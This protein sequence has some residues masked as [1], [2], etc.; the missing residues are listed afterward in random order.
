MKEEH[1]FHNP[2]LCK[3]PQ[4]AYQLLS[5]LCWL[6]NVAVKTS[7]LNM[8]NTVFL[9][10]RSNF[11]DDWAP[12][13][14]WVAVSR[15]LEVRKFP[16]SPLSASYAAACPTASFAGRIWRKTEAPRVSVNAGALL[17][18][19]GQ[20]TARLNPLV[21]VDFGALHPAPGQSASSPNL[22]AYV[23]VSVLEKIGS[24]GAET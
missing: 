12:H 20:T 8:T 2:S 13:P 17:H 16:C 7:K 3:P 6:P 4:T 19:L 11:W 24:S 5:S 18:A 21:H 10:P 9:I 14:I 15:S 23:G 1:H 22:R